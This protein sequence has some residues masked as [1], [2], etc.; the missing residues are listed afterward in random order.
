M[1]HGAQ[2]TFPATMA[3]G[4][5]LSAEVKLGRSWQNMFLVI[6]SMTSNSEIR[7]QVCDVSG[8]TYRQLMHPSINSSTVATNIYKIASSVTSVAVPIPA[9][10]QYMK[11]ETTATV[12]GGQTFK[13]I[14]GD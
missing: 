12:D 1:G 4:G 14:C 13:V 2:S 9:G 5:T 6:P 11:V 7:I 3:S 8:G 10:Y